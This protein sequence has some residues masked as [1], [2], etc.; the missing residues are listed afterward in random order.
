MNMAVAMY[1]KDS[2]GAVVV[3]LKVCASLTKSRP[4]ASAVGVALFSYP[5]L[6]I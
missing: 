2:V 3:K 6:I 1:I 5:V 4:F